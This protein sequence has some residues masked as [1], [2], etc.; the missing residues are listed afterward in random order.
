MPYTKA[1]RFTKNPIE[2][3]VAYTSDSVK[4][5]TAN[6]TLT[7]ADNGK[8]VLAADKD[9]V[10]SLPAW[11]PNLTFTVM[12][13]VINAGATGTSVSPVATDKI[14]APGSLT[15]TVN[16][17]IINTAATDVLGDYVTV[18]SGTTANTWYVIGMN[19]VWAAEA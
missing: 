2:A 9:L 19:G 8:F 7:A 11:E 15:P 6:T 17:D 16:K 18:Q 14:Y 12:T 13:Y 3:R 10:I 5:V 4:Y 1:T